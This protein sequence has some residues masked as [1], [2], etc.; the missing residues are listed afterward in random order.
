MKIGIIVQTRMGSTRLPG[1]VLMKA[2]E[3]NLML[4]YSINQLKY[5]KNSDKIIIATSNLKRDDPIEEHCKNLNIDYFRG[6]EQDVLDRHYQCAK[7]FSLSHIVRIPSDKPLIDPQI[8]D[9]TIEF[10]KENIFDYVANFEIIQKDN[11]SIFN[12]TYPS[13]TE[14][15]VFSFNALEIA[16]KNAKTSDEREHVTSHLYL[17]PK[18]FKLK[19]IQ[20][21]ENLSHFR[22]SLDYKNDVHLIR[23][24]IKR[25]SNRPILTNDIIKLLDNN[26]QLYKINKI[27]N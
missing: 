6:N 12:S 5:S 1:K 17:N 11:S 19:Y 24:I 18:I 3:T 25:I 27:V 13:G 16:W 8:V 21:L 9:S 10:F 14:V 26:P 2:D 15:E 4:D 20:Q 23:E 7:K 22:W